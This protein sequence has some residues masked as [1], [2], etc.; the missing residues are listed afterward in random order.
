M[1]ETQP[2]TIRLH[3]NDNVVVARDEIAQGY[4]V[5]SEAVA[6]NAMIPAGHKIA[7]LAI[8]KDEPVRKY[9]QIH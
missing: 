5:A 2:T 1:T 3:N 4:N 7:T 6:A 8:A 9:D